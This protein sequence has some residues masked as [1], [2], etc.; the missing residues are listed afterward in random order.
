MGYRPTVYVWLLE[1]LGDKIDSEW[2]PRSYGDRQVQSTQSVC[3][4]AELFRA[5]LHFAIQHPSQ[6]TPNTIQLPRYLWQKES[7]R[8]RRGIGILARDSNMGGVFQ[9]SM[10]SLDEKVLETN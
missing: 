9:N 3:I 1:L 10:L 7:R 4:N 5:L 6:I 2:R 8:T